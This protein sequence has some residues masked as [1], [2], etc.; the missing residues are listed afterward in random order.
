MKVLKA[1]SLF[2]C[3][4]KKDQPIQNSKKTAIEVGECGLTD[5]FTRRASMDCP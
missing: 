4:A 5:W 3:F 2:P 1:E